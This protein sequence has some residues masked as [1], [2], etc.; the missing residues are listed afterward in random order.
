MEEISAIATESLSIVNN[1]IAGY[2]TAVSAREI[3]FEPLSKLVTRAMN[4]LKASGV[5]EQVYDQVNTVA[6]KV[7][8]TRASALVK[9]VPPEEGAEPEPVVRQVSAA[10]MSYD[11]RAENFG[12]MVQLLA[13]I[14][15]YNPNESDLKVEYLGELDAELKVKNNAVIA[16]AVSLSNSRI[17]RNEVLYSDNTGLCNAG[18]TSKNYVKAV[19]GATSPQ[20]KQISKLQFKNKK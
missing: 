5:P 20:F 10:Q 3:M 2:N 8:G 12:K 15:E 14:P 4:F 13:N 6:R 9:P 11:S 18:Q 17:A 19:F 16:A 1:F 7:K